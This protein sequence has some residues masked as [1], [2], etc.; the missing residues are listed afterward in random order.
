MWIQTSSSNGYDP[1]RISC[2][3]SV[4]WSYQ[5]SSTNFLEL[6]STYINFSWVCTIFSLPI[7]GKPSGYAMEMSSSNYSWRKFVFT[8]SCDVW[9]PSTQLS[10]FFS[11][12]S[13]S[14]SIVVILQ[15]FEFKKT[16]WWLIGGSEMTTIDYF[17]WQ[18]FMWGW[19]M[20]GSRETHEPAD[21]DKMN[22]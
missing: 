1:S 7:V 4:A 3:H 18:G 11:F 15:I 22:G 16:T 20:V 14:L 9:R 13:R 2:T 19:C 12:A 17:F 21:V 6:A 10:N 5:T 8:S